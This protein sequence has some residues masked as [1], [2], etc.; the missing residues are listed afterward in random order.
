MPHAHKACPKKKK[1]KTKIAHIQEKKREKKG[2]RGI[3][4]MSSSTIHKKKQ[5]IHTPAYLDHGL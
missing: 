5:F 4:Q 2:E 3:M 1:K